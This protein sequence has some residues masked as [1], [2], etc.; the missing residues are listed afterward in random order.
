[1]AMKSLQLV[2][3]EVMGANVIMVNY[4]YY[5]FQTDKDVSADAQ[6]RILS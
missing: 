1:M 4:Q 3:G 6:H 2:I 5:T